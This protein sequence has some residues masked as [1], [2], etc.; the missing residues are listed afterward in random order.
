MP[1]V[2]VTIIMSAFLMYILV[3]ILVAFAQNPPW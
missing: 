2:I 1:K 3:A